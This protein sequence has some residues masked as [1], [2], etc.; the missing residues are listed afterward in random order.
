MLGALIAMGLMST[1]QAAG[2]RDAPGTQLTVAQ[3]NALREPIYRHSELTIG[4]TRVLLITRDYGSGLE[5]RDA[6]LYLWM[7]TEWGLFAYRRTNSA[8]VSMRV[9]GGTLALVTKAGNTV[10]SLPVDSI[11]AKYDAKEH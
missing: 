7:D 8:Q 5:L 1:G 11:A 10:L 9:T 4:P 3:A 6:Y 2:E